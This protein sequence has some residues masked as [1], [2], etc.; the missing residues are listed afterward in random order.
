MKKN[1]KIFLLGGA[2]R[3][4]RYSLTLFLGFSLVHCSGESQSE[5]AGR[6]PLRI[7]QMEPRGPDVL[8]DIKH[9][10]LESALA[11][12]T[13]APASRAVASP[14]SALSKALIKGIVAA[15]G[16]PRFQI[17]G[18]L[19]EL[20]APLST[21]CSGASC[22][23]LFGLNAEESESYLDDLYLK[24][25][26]SA[27]LRD[28][29][30]AREYAWLVGSLQKTDQT[31]WNRPT[32]DGVSYLP[33]G[34]ID[35]TEGVGALMDLP[36]KNGTRNLDVGGGAHDSNTRYLGTRGV[37]NYVY[38]P[39]ARSESHNREIL[40]RVKAA[41][42][43]SVTSMSIL[44]VID[45]STARLNHILLCQK[46][47]KPGGKGYFKVW[48]G[49]ASGKGES[50][51]GGYQS[52]RAVQSY[53]QDVRQVFGETQVLYDEDLQALVAIKR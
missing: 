4:R 46:S 53:L 22:R 51:L 14:R 33:S 23:R 45:D 43:D 44:N 40:R 29:E 2:P 41:P 9:K 28:A 3:F 38:D 37:T 49:N 18:I 32:V 36:L 25:K 42:V 13:H 6:I 19:D 24:V 16:L 47:L 35:R 39:F 26:K 21:A 15:T 11:G 30:H 8:R 50:I 52:N 31:A 7:P 1:K 27:A 12:A 48:A 20:L 5:T 17:K 10:I 34:E